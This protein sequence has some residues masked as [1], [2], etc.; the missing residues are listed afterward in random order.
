MRCDGEAK[1]FIERSGKEERVAARPSDALAI[2]QDGRWSEF[3]GCRNSSVRVVD[4]IEQQTALSFSGNSFTP[5]TTMAVVRLGVDVGGTNTYVVP[6]P[7]D[8]HRQRLH[9]R[10]R[11]AQRIRPPGPRVC[12]APDHPRCHPGHPVGYPNRPQSCPTCHRYPGDLHRHDCMLPGCILVRNSIPS[13][14]L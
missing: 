8:S 1:G 14:T 3:C 13:S 12:Q 7:R 10:R 6:P 9:Q 2:V 11:P 5:P 4:F